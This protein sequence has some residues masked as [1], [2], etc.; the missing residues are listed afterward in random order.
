MVCHVGHGMTGRKQMEL[1]K[2]YEQINEKLLEERNLEL[3]QLPE[4]TLQYIVTCL[5]YLG[6]KRQ[7]KPANLIKV[8]VSSISYD[9]IC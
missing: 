9:E 3:Y 6:L 8:D 1:W 5:D 2:F 7:D 4:E